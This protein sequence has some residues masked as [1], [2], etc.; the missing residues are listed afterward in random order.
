MGTFARHLRSMSLKDRLSKK[1]KST[2]GMKQTAYS[3]PIKKKVQKKQDELTTAQEKGKNQRKV[4]ADYWKRVQDL[5]IKKELDA[6]LPK[7]SERIKR[8]YRKMKKFTL[9]M[10][11]QDNRKVSE[12]NNLFT[13]IDNEDDLFSNFFV[14]TNQVRKLQN[15]LGTKI[16]KSRQNLE[17]LKDIHAKKYYDESIELNKMKNENDEWVNIGEPTQKELKKDYDQRK[18]NVSGTYMVEFKLKI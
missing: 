4:H 1:N 2:K 15:H 13:T 17:L 16:T 10:N 3:V 11:Y 6:L 7:R 18:N 9:W 5:K 14:I 8:K 12:Q